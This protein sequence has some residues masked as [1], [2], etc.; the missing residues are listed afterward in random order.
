MT[1]QKYQHSAPSRHNSLQSSQLYTK[2]ERGSVT[3]G[4]FTP[5]S[6]STKQRRGVPRSTSSNSKAREERDSYHP[7]TPTRES[8]MIKQSPGASVKSGT[9]SKSEYADEFRKKVSTSNT[10]QITKDHSR[11]SRKVIEGKDRMT[12]CALSHLIHASNGIS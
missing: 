8:V 2:G 3:N 7:L 4:N 9:S 1:T 5:S 10:Q 6:P 12:D 11:N